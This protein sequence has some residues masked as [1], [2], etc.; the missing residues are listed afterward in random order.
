MLRYFF[1]SL[2]LAV[3]AVIA[4]AGFRGDKSEKPPIVIFPDMDRQP[5]YDAQHR[6]DF[7]ADTRAARAPIEGTVPQGFTQKGKYLTNEGNNARHLNGPAGFSQLPGY[8]DTGLVGENWGNGIPLEPM[9]LAVL[10]RGR[11]RYNINCA[12]CHGVAGDGNGI[13]GKMGFG[14]IANLLESRF[15]TMPD[16]HIFYTITHGKGNMGPYGANITVEDRW[17]IIAYL[18][19]LQKS[20]GASLNDVPE[21]LRSNLEK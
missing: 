14:G 17:A 3:I 8:I 12:M 6:S 15:S 4:I 20:Q 9:N 18:R 16:G 10:E 13:I 7:Y 11:E 1:T 5:R 2:I 19:A 21:N